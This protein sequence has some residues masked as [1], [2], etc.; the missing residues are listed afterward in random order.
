MQLDLRQKKRRNEKR[1]EVFEMEA[2]MWTGFGLLIILVVVGVV[3]YIQKT[4]E[5]TE[6]Y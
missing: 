4:N 3:L 2:H 1:E 6:W 5:V